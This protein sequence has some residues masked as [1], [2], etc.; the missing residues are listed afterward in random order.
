MKM[1]LRI[2]LLL[3]L[4]LAAELVR[5]VPEI[6]INAAEEVWNIRAP[7]PVSWYGREEP[8]KALDLSIATFAPK[9]R[10]RGVVMAEVVAVNALACRREFTLT[11]MDISRDFALEPNGRA[12]FLMPIP[13]HTY[14]YSKLVERTGGRR[15]ENSLALHYSHPYRDSNRKFLL[16]SSAFQAEPVARTFRQGESAS[17]TPKQKARAHSPLQNS[18]R[19]GILARPPREWPA[20]PRCYSPYDAVILSETDWQ[21]LGPATRE[22]L[23]LYRLSG[24]FLLRTS[25]GPDGGLPATLDPRKL[26][27]DLSDASKTLYDSE[28]TSFKTSMANE[29]F[30]IGSITTIPITTLLVILTV[31]AV[32]C[33]PFCVWRM[34]RR[35]RRLQLLGVLPAAAVGFTLVI[36]AIALGVYGVTPS[37]RVQSVTD[38]DQ[39]TGLAATTG[40]C[41]IYSPVSLDGKL[42]L[43][44]DCGSCPFRAR[45][46]ARCA[47]VR[48]SPSTATT[49]PRP[50]PSPSSASP[51][52]AGCANGSTSSAPPTAR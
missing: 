22:A 31:F 30:P 20:D 37:I 43:P 11:L 18:Y 3:S 17:L 44:A 38:L 25:A 15:I 26:H 49:G 16:I 5:A 51:A 28:Q 41:A 47:S 24:G 10:G 35:G 27:A 19:V 2:A 48:T 1:K 32:G 33:V 4:A 52:S 40:H 12:H 42:H 36:V 45:T 34:A 8:P 39:T 13:A 6:K 9:S 29:Y 7:T 14:Q 21:D 46:W 50:S 23:E